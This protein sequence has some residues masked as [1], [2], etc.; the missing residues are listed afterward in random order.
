MREAKLHA[1]AASIFFKYGL[2]GFHHTFTKFE[3]HSNN[4]TDILRFLREHMDTIYE[5]GFLYRAT[6]ITV[7]ELRGEGEIQKDF[8]GKQ[9]A[10]LERA[11]IFDAVDEIQKKFGTYS[12]SL[13]SSLSSINTRKEIRKQDDKRDTYLWNLPLPYLGEVS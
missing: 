4:P 11:K 8:F 9:E 13:V 2:R 7:I 1:G 12:I 5:Q 6:G 3:E 10:T